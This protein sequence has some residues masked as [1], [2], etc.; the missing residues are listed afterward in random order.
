[1]DTSRNKR[2]DFYL[3]NRIEL[4]STLSIGRYQLKVIMRDL[5][6]GAEAEAIIPIE[7]V[8]EAGGR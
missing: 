5:V 2:R 7:I 4:P 6:S 8:A 1:V 3:I